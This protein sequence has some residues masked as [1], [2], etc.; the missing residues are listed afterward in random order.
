M[1]YIR[2]DEQQPNGMRVEKC[3]VLFCFVV[4]PPTHLTDCGLRSPNYVTELPP[5]DFETNEALETAVSKY[6]S[7]VLVEVQSLYGGGGGS[8]ACVC[9][10]G[11]MDNQRIVWIH[12]S[13]SRQ[14]IVY[15]YILHHIYPPQFRE[16]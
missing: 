14:P 10:L 15:L 6:L 1:I 5:S 7:A 12:T 11:G 2:N 13:Y 4:P 3:V 9:V 8:P 16:R